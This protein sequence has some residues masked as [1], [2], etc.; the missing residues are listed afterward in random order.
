MRRPGA[1]LIYG[2]AFVANS[3]SIIMGGT[4]PVVPDTTLWLGMAWLTAALCVSFWAF[5]NTKLGRVTLAQVVT[6]A[7]VLTAGSRAIGAALYNHPVWARWG[8]GS[9]WTMLTVS[10]YRIH[11][12]RR[13]YCRLH[14]EVH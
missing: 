5:P 13:G 11:V 7:L 9:I 12:V 4:H 6:A 14:G 10:F 3:V 2:A 1:Y 8:G